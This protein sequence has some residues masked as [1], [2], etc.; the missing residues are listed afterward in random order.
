MDYMV[1]GNQLARSSLWMTTFYQQSLQIGLARR[2]SIKTQSTSVKWATV[3]SWSWCNAFES[4]LVW[5]V[6]INLASQGLKYLNSRWIRFCKIVSD[7]VIRLTQLSR[8]QKL[9]S[10]FWNDPTAQCECGVTVQIIHLIMGRPQRHYRVGRVRGAKSVAL[11]A[12]TK[13]KIQKYR[14]PSNQFRTPVV[15]RMLHPLHLA[16]SS[17]CIT[18]R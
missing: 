8:G 14:T 2:D 6:L 1:R 12:E 15:K 17:L 16:G 10:S 13:A 18:V 11:L 4:K 3:E 7:S 9:G 5:K